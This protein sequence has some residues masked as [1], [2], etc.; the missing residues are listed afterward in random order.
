[1]QCPRL[2]T[3]TLTSRS[4]PSH[5]IRE[6][7]TRFR[8]Q[9]R[10]LDYLRRPKR[11][12]ILEGVAR[13]LIVAKYSHRQRM[14]AYLCNLHSTILPRPHLRAPIVRTRRMEA[15]LNSPL[16]LYYHPKVL[17]RRVVRTDRTLLRSSHSPPS[18]ST[19]MHS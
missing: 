8:W 1:M 5:S 19:A 9:P 17:Q 11:S 3:K 4:H 6:T 12:A 16:Y 18:T 13:G 10:S 7:T 14:D 15:V 2:A